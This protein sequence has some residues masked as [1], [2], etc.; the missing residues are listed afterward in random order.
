MLHAYLAVSPVSVPIFSLFFS[1]H[2]AS[3]TLVYLEK[4]IEMG[5]DTLL[6]DE[7]TCASNAMIRDRKMMQLVASDK[8]REILYAIAFVP[9]VTIFVPQGALVCHLYNELFLQEPITPF[10]H[11][12][13]SLYDDKGISSVLVIGGAG[14]YFDKADTVV[15]MDCYK[16]MDVTERAKAIV[17]NNPPQPGDETSNSVPFRS[18]RPRHVIG[19]AFSANGK[20]K[21]VSRGVVTYGDTELDL[22]ALEQIVSKSQTTAISNALQRLPSVALDARRTLAETVWEI[23]KIIDEQGLDALAPNQ[24]QGAMSKPRRFEIAGAINR[25]RRDQSVVQNP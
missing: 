19:N 25:L 10:L 8:V 22:S 11:V 7:D 3:F 17:A 15:M 1:I 5:A 16:C 14:D 9:C 4:S 23:E 12:V 20:V 18:F 13:R 21:V 24:F 6:I 2:V